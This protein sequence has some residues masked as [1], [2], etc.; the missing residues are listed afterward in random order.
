MS[1]A[2]TNRAKSSSPLC[3]RKDVRCWTY[4]FLDVPQG[5]QNRLVLHHLCPTRSRELNQVVVPCCWWFTD[6]ASQIY[7]YTIILGNA[8]V[9]AFQRSHNDFWSIR[10]IEIYPHLAWVLAKMFAGMSAITILMVLWTLT[11][12][13]KWLL[14][15]IGTLR[16][17][18]VAFKRGLMYL[19]LY[20]Y[21]M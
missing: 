14:K 9:N 16:Y 18:F 4:D 5:L 6:T 7:R 11:D 1:K 17:E 21:I 8:L 2:T 12:H 19:L 15:F 3:Q 10:L 13:Y 20:R